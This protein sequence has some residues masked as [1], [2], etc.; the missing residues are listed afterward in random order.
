MNKLGI[1]TIIENSIDSQI[2]SISYFR[3][4]L[5]IENLKTAVE[6]IFKSKGKLILTGVGKSGHIA[7]KLAATFSSTST[8]SFF[9]NPTDGLHGDLGMIEKDDI[10]LAIGKSGTS[11]ELTSIL[12]T[13]SQI[14]V[15]LISI[16][17][18][19]NSPLAKNSDICIRMD[20]LKEACPLNL[21]PTSST[22]ISLILGD[23]IA[24]TLMQ[25]RKF[26]KEDF[27][28]YHPAGRLG[29]R[30]SLKVEMIMRKNLELA[31]V[32]E[33]ANL[34]DIIKEISSKCMGASCV[35]DKKNKL[36][37]II[38]DFDIRKILQKQTLNLTAKDIMNANPTC[39]SK[40]SNAYKVLVQ[41]ENRKKPIS[42]APIT[43]EDGS[44]VGM[45]LIH[46]LIQKGL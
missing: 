32:L 12:P 36:L 22:T 6:L 37:G 42:V 20:V 11:E 33:T 16:T 24:L 19:I 46:D 23:T 4:N 28:F 41:M 1:Q 15:K 25:M 44:L 5:D 14:G 38:T 21:A 34:S 2:E 18:D 26:T 45:V 13:I 30:L 7:K 9:I 31:K 10:V 40:S 17:A 29:K 3:E 39:F 43:E 27:A 8:P 35:V